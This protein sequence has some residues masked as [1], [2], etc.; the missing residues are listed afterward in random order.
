VGGRRRLDYT[1]YGVVVN[2]AARF[3]DANKALK[4]SICIGPDAVARL[5]GDIKLRPL[6]RIAVRGMT[7]LAEVCEPWLDSVPQEFREKYAE[8]VAAHEGAPA[9]ARELFISL[10]NELPGDPVVRM[11]LEKLPA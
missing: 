8:A 5:S 6:G 10:S 1:A 4:S 7:G 9:R 11:W 3:Q 2:K